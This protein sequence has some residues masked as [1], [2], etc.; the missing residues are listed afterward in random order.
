MSSDFIYIYCYR[1]REGRTAYVGQTVNPEK[2]D[3][4]HR[5]SSRSRIAQFIKDCE[6]VIL[7]RV[8]HALGNLAER[9]AIE[10]Y[11]SLGECWLNAAQPAQIDAKTESVGNEIYWL[12]ADR[13]F[14]S[15]AHASRETGICVNYISLAAR[16]LRA[17]DGITLEYRVKPSTEGRKFEFVSDTK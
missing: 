2:R 11:S 10:M 17:M 7:R 1:T 6:F 15:Y 16:G 9:E 3:Y 5:N 14:R 12:E 4:V 8:S 13:Y